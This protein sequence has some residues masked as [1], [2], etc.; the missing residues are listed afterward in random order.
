MGK[1]D[2]KRKNRNKHLKKKKQSYTQKDREKQTN[3]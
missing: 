2:G 3:R 1:I